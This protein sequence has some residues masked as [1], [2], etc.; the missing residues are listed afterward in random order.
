MAHNPTP[1]VDFHDVTFRDIF[2]VHL[3]PPFET[4]GFLLWMVVT[5]DQSLRLQGRYQT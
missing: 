1:S 2:A 4:D 3:S 5:E